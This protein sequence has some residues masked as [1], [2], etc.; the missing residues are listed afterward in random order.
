MLAGN[1]AAVGDRLVN[2]LFVFVFGLIWV[3]ELFFV[4]LALYILIYA[5]CLPIV[6]VVVELPYL[7]TKLQLVSTQKSLT[8]EYVLGFIY[9][10]TKPT[11]AQTP[12]SLLFFGLPIVVCY[13]L[14]FLA[15][16]LKT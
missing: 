9:N 12:L 4:L 13:H 14:I 5:T 10:Y 1:Q 2:H 15:N 16:L 7:M 11:M 3:P 6:Y 8:V